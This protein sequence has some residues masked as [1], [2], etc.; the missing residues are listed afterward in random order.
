M[1]R[2]RGS[3]LIFGYKLRNE[4][5]LYQA[6]DSE[7]RSDLEKLNY[8][9]QYKKLQSK[10]NT[11]IHLPKKREVPVEDIE[12]VVD[13]LVQLMTSKPKDLKKKPTI[14]VE[15]KTEPQISS[16]PSPSILPILSY[17]SLNNNFAIN[18][19]PVFSQGFF[20]PSLSLSPLMPMTSSADWHLKLARYIQSEILTVNHSI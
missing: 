18:D 5:Y 7:I 3:N 9:S 17:F 11:E 2:T 14:I 1:S 13:G 8:F 20:Y 10:L 12:F 19:M 16:S 6:S 4:K 15:K